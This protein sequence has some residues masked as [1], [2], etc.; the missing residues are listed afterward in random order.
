MKKLAEICFAWKAI[1]NLAVSIS[2]NRSERLSVQCRQHLERKIRFIFVAYYYFQL[3]GP[4][5]LATTTLE[6]LGIR[7]GN[8]L[9][10]Y[11]PLEI[12]EE[13]L[14]KINAQVEKSELERQHLEEV[15]R[16]KRVENLERQRFEEER[17]KVVRHKIF[18]VSLR[19]EK[20]VDA[21]GVGTSS[22]GRRRSI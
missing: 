8:A 15:F 5:V 6:S 12:S 20:I 16:K 17:Q 22:C 14:A 21:L 2:P 1:S 11:V 7:G 10:R 3:K 9:I 19:R 18:I 4:L 13:E